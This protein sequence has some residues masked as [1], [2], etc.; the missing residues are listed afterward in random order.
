MDTRRLVLAAIFAAIPVVLSP[1]N[2]PVAAIGAKALPWQHMVNAIAGVLLGPWYAMLAAAVTATIRISMGTGTPL[3]FPGG[4]AGALVVGLAYRIWRDDRL[5]LLE[6]LGTGPIG[7]TVG[8][9]LVAPMVMGQ[10]RPLG[11]M[12]I[13]FLAS[14][15]PGAIIGFVVLKVIR[16]AGVQTLPDAR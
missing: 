12:M 13:A 9:L 2:I 14:S 8:A 3:A 7:A 5:A 10:A 15:I 4:M 11:A 6:P 16:R 1:L